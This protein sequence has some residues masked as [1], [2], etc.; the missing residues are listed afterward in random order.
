MWMLAS[1]G[2]GSV[3]VCVD[4]MYFVDVVH[5]VMVWMWKLMWLCGRSTSRHC[6]CGRL[7]DCMW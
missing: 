4:V 5:L 3:S 6:G 7:C 2:C 1:C